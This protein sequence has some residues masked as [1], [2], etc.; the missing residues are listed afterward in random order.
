VSGK[1]RKAVL[2]HPIDGVPREDDFQVVEEPLPRPGRGEILI[3]HIYLSLDPYQRPAIAGR[4]GGGHGPLGAGDMPPGETVGQVV[5]SSHGRFAVGEYVRSFGGWQEFSVSDGTRT[6]AID[7]QRAP[8]SAYLGVLGMPGLT[9][10]ASI[11]KL[12][13]VQAGQTVLVSSAAGVV[14]ATLGQIAI[15]LGARAIGIAGSD[16]KCA[17]VTGELGFS[18]CVNYKRPDFM[19]RLR[20]AVGEGADIYHDNVGGQML[21]DAMSVLKPYGTVILCGLMSQY[22]VPERDRRHDFNLALPVLKRAVMKGLVVYDF[23][24]RRQEFFDQVSP[25]VAAGL[26]KFREDR[27]AGI[28]KTGAHFARLMRG[29]NFGKALVVLAPET[30]RERF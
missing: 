16:E 12:A 1:N 18:A 20:A 10:W 13:N 27:A 4:H 11:V 15:R 24:D 28:E 7:R 9:A 22:N 19:E 17:F 26:V 8:L 23:E 25:W 5:Q 2:R 6:V 29:E 30:L 21:N 3:R 14:G